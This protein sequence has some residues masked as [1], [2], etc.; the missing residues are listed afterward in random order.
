MAVQ[1]ARNI[2]WRR[3]L[4]ATD[5][6]SLSY[7]DPNRRTFGQR[8]G[9][10]LTQVAPVVSVFNPLVGAA[11]YAIGSSTSPPRAAPVA[12]DLTQD[13]L[14]DDAASGGD[15]GG[16]GAT[17]IIY[18]PGVEG[19][20]GGIPVRLLTQLGM[21]IAQQTPA[22][23]H[24]L[25]KTSGRVGGKRSARKRRAKAKASPRRKRRKSKGMRKLKKG[26]AAAKAWGRKMRR[27]RK[28]K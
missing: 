7:Y 9:R 1:N 24:A 15:A 6:M 25:A 2:A 23:R 5:T 18:N 26:S 22:V 10:A 14:D 21:G 3:S 20:L 27:L 28:G 17:T 19:Q 8:F 12:D 11:L 13:Q 16:G 4:P